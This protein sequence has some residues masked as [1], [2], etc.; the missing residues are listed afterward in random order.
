MSRKLKLKLGLFI[1]GAGH[2]AVGWRHPQ[3][4]SGSENFELIK[5]L[6]QTAERAKLDMIFWRMD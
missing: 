1:Q 4:Q 6:A 3:A 5:Q 2:H